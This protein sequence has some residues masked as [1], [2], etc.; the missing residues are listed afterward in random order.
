MKHAN[1]LDTAVD[2]LFQERPV[3]K[4][5]GWWKWALVPFLAVLFV[6]RSTRPVMRLSAE[7]PPAFYGYNRTLDPQQRHHE[8]RL[9]LAYW[10]VA[11]RRIQ[12]EY[13]PGK[14]LPAD[15]PPEFQVA[16]AASTLE[17]DVMAGRVHYWYRLRAVWNQRGT[18]V[19]SYGWNSDWLERS[20]NALPQYLPR[21]VTG[22]V[23]SLVDFVNDV[24]R[25][26]SFH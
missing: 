15:P 13:S 11:I 14:P 18:W 10:N 3:R 22:V 17:T 24:A 1:S 25:E 4:R 26:I 16:D 7:P 21:S 20:L 12:R 8:Q 9:A 5:S 19:V 2:H 6:Y 23:Q